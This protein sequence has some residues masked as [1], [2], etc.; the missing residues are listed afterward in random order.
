M[1]SKAN[2][3]FG[4]RLQKVFAKSEHSLQKAAVHVHSTNATMGNW[5]HGDIPYALTVLCNLHKQYNVD[6]NWLITGEEQ[7]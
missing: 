7:K 1:Q 2:R 5:A 3:E 6:L 4:E